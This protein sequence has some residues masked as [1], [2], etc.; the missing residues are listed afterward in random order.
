MNESATT[1]NIGQDIGHGNRMVDVRAGIGALA[2]LIAVLVGCEG[3]CCKHDGYRRRIWLHD[4]LS[5][6]PV[7]LLVLSIRLA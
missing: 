6:S 3:A 4:D 2:A 5:E 1:Q 7:L